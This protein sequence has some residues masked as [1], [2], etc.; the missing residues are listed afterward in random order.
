MTEWFKV[1]IL[2]ISVIVFT[3]GSNPAP[4][5][6]IFLIFR[7]VN[8]VLYEYKYGGRKVRKDI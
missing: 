4:S 1:L 5:V 2:K 7:N 3:V 6:F 8:I